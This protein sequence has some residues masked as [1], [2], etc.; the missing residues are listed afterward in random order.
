[1]NQPC[2]YKK[3]KITE[4]FDLAK[5]MMEELRFQEKEITKIVILNNRNQIIKIKDIAIRRR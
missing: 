2:S 3:I 4:P 5:I 1:M